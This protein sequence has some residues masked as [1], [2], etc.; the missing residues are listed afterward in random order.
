MLYC[1]GNLEN[2]VKEADIY[3]GATGGYQNLPVNPPVNRQGVERCFYWE[4]CQSFCQGYREG[5]EDYE[6]A[7][8]IEHRKQA[9]ARIREE[10][11]RDKI[12]E[13]TQ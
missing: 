2:A 3:G 8:G 13:N 7:R 11:E 10:R 1:M 9:E 5:C 12:A 6:T 4:E